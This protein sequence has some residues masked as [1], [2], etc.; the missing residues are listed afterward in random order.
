MLELEKAFTE[1]MY[2]TKERKFTI[3]RLLNIS[4]RQIK[5]WFQNRRMKQKREGRASGG[6]Q[7]P[8]Q[9]LLRDHDNDSN[10]SDDSQKLII[11][12]TRHAQDPARH[13]YFS[14]LELNKHS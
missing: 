2:L 5:V 12:E 11:D 4:E 8:P 7:P 13:L 14:N 1:S 3:S 9:Q 6:L 10:H